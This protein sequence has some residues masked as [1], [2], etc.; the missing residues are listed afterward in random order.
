MLLC[1]FKSELPVKYQ[2]KRILMVM[3]SHGTAG[4]SGRPTGLWLDEFATPFYAFLDAGLEVV[5]CSPEGGRIPVDPA[6]LATEH[7]SESTRRLVRH[8]CS[9]LN[10]TCK[11]SQVRAGD[12]DAVFYPGGHGP[13]WD[14]A[15]N[16]INAALLRSFDAENKLIGTVCHGAAALCG[17]CRSADGR[18]LVFRRKL[19][20]FSNAEESAAGMTE[21]VP[22]SLENRLLELGAYYNAILPWLPHVVIDQNLI[23]GQNPHSAVLVAQKM[24]ERLKS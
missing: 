1:T 24:L 2:R 19:T 22:F 3:T 5:L 13:L 8:H 16:L 4:E 14:L 21:I 17:A 9:V 6:S 23:T 20:A 7:T 11:L 18:P 15:S 10:R 12:F